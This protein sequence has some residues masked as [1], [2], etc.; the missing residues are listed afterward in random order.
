[1]A[2]QKSSNAAGGGRD[3]SANGPSSP[4]VIS[5]NLSIKG[6]LLSQGKLIIDGRIEGDVDAAEILVS[7]NGAITGNVTADSVDI[8]GFIQGDIT[9]R[10]VELKETAHIIGDT[11]HHVISIEDGAC[12]DGNFRR[13]APPAEGPKLHFD[14]P[15]KRNRRS[16]KAKIG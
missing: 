15:A 16:G 12:L 13:S 4:S 9:S 7:E 14:S 11:T 10:V 3:S 8:Y 5:A 1:M 2:R 6:N